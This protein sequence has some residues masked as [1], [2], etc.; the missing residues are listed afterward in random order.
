MNHLYIN[1][2]NIYIK[3]IYNGWINNKWKI[4]I[5]NRW[6]LKL[7]ESFSKAICS[8]A[9]GYMAGATPKSSQISH[10]KEEFFECCQTQIVGGNTPKLWI[11]FKTFGVGGHCSSLGL[12]VDSQDFQMGAREIK[13]GPTFTMNQRGRL[14][15]FIQQQGYLMR[16]IPVSQK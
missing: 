1:G 16:Y 6:I 5:F 9:R 10:W 15:R 14:I 2:W 7:T 3:N 11:Q 8:I 13:P 4:T 12:N